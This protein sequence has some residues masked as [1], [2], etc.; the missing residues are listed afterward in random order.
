MSARHSSSVD[1]QMS[2]SDG[3]GLGYAEFG[4][5]DGAPVFT[6]HAF[7]SSRLEG[8]AYHAAALKRGARVI[9]VDRPGFGLSD[10]KPARGLAD[11]PADVRELADTLD[12]DDFS[13]VGVSSGAPYAAACAL[14]LADRVRSTAMVSTFHRRGRRSGMLWSVRLLLALGRLGPLLARPFFWRFARMAEQEPTRLMAAVGP[15]FSAADGRVMDRPETAEI[16]MDGMHEAFRG[17]VGGA[18]DELRI[19][20]RPWGF[21]VEDIPGRVA[22]WHGRA[23]RTM[24]PAIAER[25]SQRI[26]KSTLRCLDGYG[27]LMMM[28]KADEILDDQLSESA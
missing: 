19:H 9:S 26:P 15:F 7:P 20:T 23:D 25:L 13:V 18:I 21:R 2:L 12:L 14:V 22:I 1:Q 16:L 27:H 4:H 8:R 3:R 5:P 24:P 28:D 17:G 11:W 6:F 10:R